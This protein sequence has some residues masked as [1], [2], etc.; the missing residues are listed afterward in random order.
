MAY[1]KQKQEK[2]V[3]SL[4]NIG[5]L[6]GTNDIGIAGGLQGLGL[7][8]EQAKCDEEAKAVR[9]GLFKVVV[10]GAFTS[11]KSTL[12]NALVGSEMLPV[13][14]NPTTAILTFIQ[15]GK[16][17]D[18]AE[19]YMAD[20]MEA[21]KMIQGECI[22]MSLSEFRKTYAYTTDDE[23]ECIETG[24][25]ERFAA[26]KYAV[27]YCSLPLMQNGV[28]VIDSP[29]L[30]DK[31]V[32][33]ELAVSVAQK[34]QA[35]IYVGTERGL[36]MPDVDYIK[37]NFRN[38]PKNV[39]FV[40]N[41]Y[42]NIGMKKEREEALLLTKMKVEDV[43]K[44][45]DG[46]IDEELRNRRVFGVSALRALD[47]R[48]GMTFDKYKECDRS[49]T[50]EERKDM[51]ERSWFK[52]FESELET[53]LTTDEKCIAQYRKCFTQMA[54]T[55]RNAE[56]ETNTRLAAL[57]AGVQA[58]AADKDA[59]AKK[60]ADIEKDIQLLEATFDGES[61]KIQNSVKDLFGGCAKNLDASWEE[62]MANLAERVDVGM[63]K[64]MAIGLKQMNPLASKESKERDMKKFMG[65]FIDVVAS[66]FVERFNAYYHE[67]I[68]IVE[69]VAKECEETIQIKIDD[70][71]KKIKG[72]RPCTEGERNASNTDKSWLQ[73][74]ISAYLGDYSKVLQGATDGKAPWMD[75]L[76]KTL[77]NTVWQVLLVY[78]L[79]AGW[80]GILIVLI[81]CIQGK[82]N[83]NETVKKILEQS[84]YSILNDM[85]KQIDKISK[86]IILQITTE[87]DK[88]KTEQCQGKKRQLSDIIASMNEIENILTAGVT[89]LSDTRRRYDNILSVMYQ[90]AVD[91]YSIVY[92]SQL[93]L[94]RL[95][96]L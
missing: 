88:K 1:S 59:A 32:A 56:S 75:Y 91:A 36:D 23:R 5:A 90:E 24:S 77:S 31:N 53:F 96:K 41:K 14:T 33:T 39:F 9:D 44:R 82:N 57:E 70:I 63:L 79:G 73:I 10:M 55:Y 83:K 3:S 61:L 21:G 86:A 15:Y 51:Y 65:K 8:L 38:C 2:L 81:E 43:F 66:Y 37:A 58:T 80:G 71:E 13:S 20:K 7:S 27:L 50:D 60:K 17:E 94:Q 35:V 46:S 18:K 52:P 49:L 40:M 30:E 25:V 45:E 26:V 48:R 22:T 95:K 16:D 64:Y 68:M 12:I 69:D 62:D 6:A 72:L 29:G 85:K 84:K 47:S 28:C 78:F 34:A 89:T 76:K 74:L 67:N 19:V 4:K 93:S 54:S 92:E 11:G 87:I 42:D